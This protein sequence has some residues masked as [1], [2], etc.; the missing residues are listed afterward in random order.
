MFY[1]QS[2]G[3]LLKLS[4]RKTCPNAGVSVIANQKSIRLTIIRLTITDYPSN[5]LLKYEFSMIILNQSLTSF[6][7]RKDIGFY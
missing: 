7:E 3:C 4:N 2:A 5:C 6:K 1:L